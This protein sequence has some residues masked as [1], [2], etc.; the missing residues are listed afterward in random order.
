MTAMVHA[1]PNHLLPVPAYDS[2][3]YDQAVFKSLIGNVRP[4]IWMVVRPSFE[5]EYAIVLYRDIEYE[6]AKGDMTYPRKAIR[7]EWL[8]SKIS[9]TQKIWAWKDIGE[10][11]SI[12]DIKPT[13]DVVKDS[14]A[15]N[16]ADYEKIISAWKVA[17][18]TTRYPDSKN[19]GLDG[20]TYQFY[21]HYN[22]FGQTWSPKEGLPLN[23]VNL[24]AALEDII[25]TKENRKS[26]LIKANE[27]ANRI[28]NT[29]PNKASN[30][31]P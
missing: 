21:A 3:G 19:M 13:D 4:E 2:D 11:R 16:K 26:A 27:I 15:V 29:N 14:I 8:L 7:D 20:T 6:E 18:K 5:E 10:G 28:I 25:K 24:G 12:L 9:A 17:L 23:I 31:T 1:N 30:P 22:L